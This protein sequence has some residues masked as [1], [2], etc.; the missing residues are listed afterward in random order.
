MCVMALISMTWSAWC[1][2]GIMSMP[3]MEESPS[4]HVK[5]VFLPCRSLDGSVPTLMLAPNGEFETAKGAVSDFHLG[6][7][8]RET[9]PGRPSIL[10]IE[11]ERETNV[12]P[13]IAQ[14]LYHISR[15][16]DIAKA[17]PCR[18]ETPINAIV[19]FRVRCPLF[20]D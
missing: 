8:L 15:A 13:G 6:D 5:I 10:E 17:R 19:V 20:C 9:C 12:F 1:A 11:I 14:G 2:N 3:E 7:L 4:C 16:L 18:S